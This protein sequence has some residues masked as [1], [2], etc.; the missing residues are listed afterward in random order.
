MSGTAKKTLVLAE[1]PDQAR[2]FVPMLERASG[3]KFEKAAGYY[4][5]PS[6]YVSWFYG[7]LLEA[8]MP[9]EY[10]EKYKEWTFDTLPIFVDE[11]VYKFRD[12]VKNQADIILRLANSAHT[13]VCATDP[14]REGQGIFDTFFKYYKIQRPVMK[15][16]WA[17]SLTDKDLDKAWANMKD[18]SEYKNLSLARELRSWSDWLVGMNASHAYTVATKAKISIGRVRTPTLALIVERDRTVE[19]YK[20]SF[21]YKLIGDW[22][23]FRFTYYQDK[24]CKLEI[25]VVNYG[26]W[27]FEI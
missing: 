14:D 19:N 8:L 25:C 22:G 20:E 9:D 24:E 15:R 16:L 12:G 21:Y 27:R 18:L 13:V 5:S 3:E 7:H 6:Y 2:S 26:C 1:K 10:D 11:L 23:G 4:E 17:P